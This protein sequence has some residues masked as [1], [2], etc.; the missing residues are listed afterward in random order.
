MY[1]TDIA[2]VLVWIFIGG[3]IVLAVHSFIIHLRTV[4]L[5]TLAEARQHVKKGR[6]GYIRALI[7]LII[8]DS[9]AWLLFGSYY[10]AST[11]ITVLSVFNLIVLLKVLLGL[12][13]VMLAKKRIHQIKLYVVDP[14]R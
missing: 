6:S 4:P 7:A 9:I 10:S 13:E 12:Q 14:I 2:L 5:Y 8:G 1:L 11:T 3:F